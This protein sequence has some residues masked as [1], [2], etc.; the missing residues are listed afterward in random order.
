MDMS[1]NDF[2][3]VW[4]QQHYCLIDLKGPIIDGYER[5]GRI[6]TPFNGPLF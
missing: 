3:E 1:E 6:N 4:L 5:F 2:G